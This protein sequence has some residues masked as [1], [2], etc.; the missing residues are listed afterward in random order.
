MNTEKIVYH[1]ATLSEWTKYQELGLIEP[2]SLKNEGFIHCSTEEQLL[3]TVA[4][5]YAFEKEVV[6][7][8]L[9]VAHFGSDLVFEDTYG[10]GEFPHIYRAIQ[11][12]EIESAKT[13][14]VN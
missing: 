9:N 4:R 1:I 2:A 7:I 8:E 3:G 13:Q 14:L 12:N 6:L 5:F 11:L 10:H